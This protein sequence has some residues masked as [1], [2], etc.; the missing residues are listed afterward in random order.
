MENKFMRNKIDFKEAMDWEVVTPTAFFKEE[1]RGKKAEKEIVE[2]YLKSAEYLYMCFIKD[3]NPLQGLKVF[4]ND[5]MCM[6]FLYL[7]RHTLELTLK[8]KIEKKQEKVEVGHSLSNLWK[9]LK[10]IASI[11][12]EEYE[13]LIEALSTID[14]DGCKLRYIKDQKG[15]EYDNIPCFIKPYEI[16]TTIRKLHDELLK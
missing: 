16:I 11:D 6:P 9:K 10:K 8:M 5:Q 12:N 13:Q 14:N 1:C 4:K 3:N 15:N 7:C 2:G